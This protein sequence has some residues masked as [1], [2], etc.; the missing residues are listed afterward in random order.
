MATKLFVNL[1]VKD[2]QKSIDFFGSLGFSFN[3]QFTDDNA[4][5]MIIS[6]DI[7]AML[8][9]EPF[10]RTFTP[11]E[12]SDASVSAEVLLTITCDTREAVDE[13]IRKAVGA[14]GR[15]FSDPKDYGFLYGHAFEDLDGHVWQFIWATAYPGDEA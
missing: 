3:P 4:T 7:F 8:L 2:L 15:T 10:F 13:M 9:V 14:G 6:E 5:C 12:I 1:P 11:R